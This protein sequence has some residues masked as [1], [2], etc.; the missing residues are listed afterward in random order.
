MEKRK[1]QGKSKEKERQQKMT[2]LKKKVTTQIELDLSNLFETTSGVHHKGYQD[3]L[4][5][6][7]RTILMGLGKASFIKEEKA[8]VQEEITALVKKQTDLDII[9]KELEKISKLFPVE[10]ISGSNGN[11]PDPMIEKRRQEWIDKKLA[12]K[13]SRPKPGSKLE[14]MVKVTPDIMLE[15]WNSGDPLIKW[16]W[17]MIIE[18][19]QFESKDEAVSWFDKKIRELAAKQ[20]TLPSS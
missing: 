5:I 12:L 16:N 14:N 11:S 15:E 3:A 1:R 2:K 20:D 18:K 10:G 6:G 4:D 8:R 19:Y 7:V 13:I 9:E 17:T